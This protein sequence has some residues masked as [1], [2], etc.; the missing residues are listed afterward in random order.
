LIN[1]CINVDVIGQL[2]LGA[3]GGVGY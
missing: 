1:K 2:G 3:D